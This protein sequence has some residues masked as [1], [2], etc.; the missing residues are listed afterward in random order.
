MFTYVR[1]LASLRGANQSLTTID[2]GNK[3]V[4][5]LTATYSRCVLVLSHPAIDHLVSLDVSQVEERFFQASPTLTVRQWL[6]SIGDEDLPFQNAIPTVLKSSVIAAEAYA[7]GY[8][9]QK[10]HPTA[11]AGTALLDSELTQLLLTRHDADYTDMYDHLLSTVN[12]LFHLTD[13]DVNGF[14]INDGGRSVNHSG[15]NEVG[16][17]SFKGVGKVR[18]YPIT[19]AMISSRRGLAL[20]EGVVITAPQANFAGKFVLVS[21]GGYLH[22]ANQQYKVVGDKSVL[23]EWWKLPMQRRYHH[24]RKLMDWST[25]TRHMSLDPN[26]LGEID[27]DIM[28]QDVCIREYLKLSQTFIITIETDNFFSDLIPLERTGLAGRYYSHSKPTKP[29]VLY[30][31]LMPSYTIHGSNGMFCLAV[32]DNNHP[33]Y[34]H[35]TLGLVDVVGRVN[36]A[37]I[38]HPNKVYGSAYFLDMW[39]ER[40]KYGA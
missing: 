7:A 19:D 28:N 37:T 27:L 12:G 16:L 38:H 5:D 4:R 23:I 39:N 35:D 18:T 20:K 8:D 1:A 13:A 9:V 26:H 33:D 29:L 32:E 6:V 24:T 30:N 36:D 3:L 2:V 15:K 17:L 25:V 34:L 31:G 11:G 14:R 40:L 10:V 22:V 21:I